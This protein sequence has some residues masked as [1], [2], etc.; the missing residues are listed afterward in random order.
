MSIPSPS[1]QPGDDLRHYRIERQIGA[2]GMG[3]VYEARHRTLDYRLAIKEFA[4]PT[5]TNE[6]DTQARKLHQA[7]LDALFAEARVLITLE[8]HDI[9]AGGADIP[10]VYDLFQEAGAWFLVMEYIGGKTL[11]LL[12]EEQDGP[13]PVEEGV[14][15]GDSILRTLTFL[16]NQNP[17]VI[18]RDLK[19]GN[20][21]LNEQGRVVILDF[22]VAK[23]GSAI[24]REQRTSSTSQFVSFFYSPPE[25][26]RGRGTDARSDFFALGGTLYHLLTG[27]RPPDA[28]E[29]V[30]TTLLDRQPD[31][32][33]LASEVNVAIPRH[34]AQALQQAL[35]IKPEQRFAT[36]EEFRR[37]LADPWGQA[38]DYTGTAATGVV[39]PTPTGPANTAVFPPNDP[40][41]P[42]GDVVY[43]PFSAPLAPPPRRSP[44][45]NAVGVLL[46][47][48]LLVG[49]LGLWQG[50]FAL[51]GGIGVAGIAQTG[52]DDGEGDIAIPTPEI[53]IAEDTA[54]PEPT[55][56][57]NGLPTAVSGI[58]A[59]SGVVV[60]PTSTR[61]PTLTVPPTATETTTATPTEIPTET[62]TEIVI[63]TPT[64]TP[65]PV[66]PSATTAAPFA[67][68]TPVPTATPTA[69]VA[70]NTPVPPPPTATVPPSP[71]RP[72]I[73]VRDTPA[74]W[75]IGVNDLITLTWDGG[76]G[77]IAANEGAY[78]RVYQNGVF[79]RNIEIPYIQ[80]NSQNFFPFRGAQVSG[81][82]DRFGRFTV[83][84]EIV[85]VNGASL[86][87][88]QSWDFEVG[89]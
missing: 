22:G 78:I 28:Q 13:I 73:V 54:T 14:R 53:A 48:A 65:R 66:T 63:P 75:Q 72:P 83:Y 71:S 7:A 18:H 70:T 64:A 16:H 58:S 15:W 44:W 37:A 56:T 17:P 79:Q 6:E 26:L 46:L 43:R 27:E 25:Q 2:G 61:L 35:A 80:W 42:T 55:F 39:R 30:N 9:P 57:P 11:D 69:P 76:G 3:V 20:L 60:G 36:A 24:V 88:S 33:R 12:L 62:P 32:L 23:S 8:H 21:K 5:P 40:S 47:L 10:K 84:L 49:G 29:R 4:I 51:P 45:L 41:E 52:G 85:D 81:G 77:P 38:A 74:W 19:P 50:W 89:P 1:L 68:D 31:P 87:R 86:T 82:P 67:T 59:E 34:V